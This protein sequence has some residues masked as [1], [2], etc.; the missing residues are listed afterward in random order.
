MNPHPEDQQDNSSDDWLAALLRDQ[1]AMPGPMDGGFTD[2]L[3][4][5]LPPPQSPRRRRAGIGLPV[6]DACAMAAAAVLVA[7][8]L[9]DALRPFVD[10]GI[11]ADLLSREALEQ[12]LPALAMLAW[13]G[14][15]SVRQ[16]LDDRA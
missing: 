4:R 15:W 5:K 2:A 1:A 13:L 11:A 14:W 7:L 16:A 10:V 6:F 8:L 9:P 12:T 3:L